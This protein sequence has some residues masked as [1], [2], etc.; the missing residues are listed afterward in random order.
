MNFVANQQSGVVSRSDSDFCV[1][2]MRYEC[3]MHEVKS[4]NSN[5]NSILWIATLA[6]PACSQ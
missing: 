6:L 5:A 3:E 2:K 4:I 1:A